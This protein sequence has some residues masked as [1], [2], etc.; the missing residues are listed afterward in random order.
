MDGTE[1]QGSR[2]GP[3]Q[4]TELPPLLPP[5][6]RAEGPEREKS[7]GG[8]EREV[9]AHARDDTGERTETWSG[10]P[11]LVWHEVLLQAWRP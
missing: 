11:S 4:E 8:N 7:S 9:R 10:G 5:A 1:P 6:K 2:L 3:W